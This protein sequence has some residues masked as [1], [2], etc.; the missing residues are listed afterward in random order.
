M[1]TNKDIVGSWFKESEMTSP[2]GTRVT[3][4]HLSVGEYFI[5]DLSWIPTHE[6]STIKRHMFIHDVTHRGII[7]HEKD[8]E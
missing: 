8:V 7:V 1:K 4:S 5:D 6:N 2:K 3:K